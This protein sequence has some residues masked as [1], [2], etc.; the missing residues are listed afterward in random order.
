MPAT[1]GSRCVDSCF[2]KT[3]CLEQLAVIHSSL[4]DKIRV[5][6]ARSSDNEATAYLGGDITRMPPCPF[7]ERQW[8]VERQRA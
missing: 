1:D 8:L 3:L 6:L 4:A 2:F 7:V 5:E